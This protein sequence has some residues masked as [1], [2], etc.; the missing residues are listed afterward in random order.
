MKNIW[1]IITGLAVILGLLGG[2]YA[3]DD[4][5]AKEELVAQS[6]EQFQ[7]QTQQTYKQ[8][9]LKVQ[10]QFYQII[11]DNLTKEM[12][13]YKRMMRENPDDQDI[14]EEYNRVMNERSKIMQKIQSLLEKI[15]G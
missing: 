7:Q 3:I 4:R 1:K 13:T 9:Q 6:L 14:H 10:L 8:F 11:Y 5:Y 12:F 15:D 2:V